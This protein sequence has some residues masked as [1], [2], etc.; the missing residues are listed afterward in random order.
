M[1]EHDYFEA[2][3]AKQELG[4]K[5]HYERNRALRMAAWNGW[6]ARS[7]LSPRTEGNA[8][9]PLTLELADA[10]F[11]CFLHRAAPDA[12]HTYECAECEEPVSMP[13][14][15]T[16]KH[17]EGCSVAKA[18]DYLARHAPH[19]TPGYVATSSPQKEIK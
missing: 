14:W 19:R 6:L 1:T 17:A 10:L 18:R 7:E 11:G 5:A 12:D 2:W 13:N 4:D 16:S 8:P 15:I 3:W 9:D